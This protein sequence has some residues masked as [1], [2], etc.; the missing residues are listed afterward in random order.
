MEQLLVMHQ[1][2]IYRTALGYLGGDG[3]AAEEVAQDVLISLSRNLGNFRGESR[4]TT[5]LYRMTVNFAKNFLVSRGRR[6]ARFVSLDPVSDEEGRNLS[7]AQTAAD[8]APD[9]RRAT[10]DREALA[11]LHSRMEQLSDEFRTVMILRFVEDRSYEEISEITSVPIGTVKSRI[12]RG[13][14]ELRRLMAD[15]LE[16]RR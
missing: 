10:A 1:D 11:I 8:E 16:A 9:P 14:A 15:V 13:R 4:L 5:W 3:E 6:N 2:R 12:N 7:P